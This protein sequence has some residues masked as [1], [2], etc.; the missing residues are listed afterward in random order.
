MTDPF[1]TAAV[2][3]LL[4]RGER[5]WAYYANLI[6][7][8]GSAR[9]VLVGDF[10]EPETEPDRL[11]E[12]Q[13]RSHDAEPDLSGILVEI[14]AWRDEGMR[15]LTVLDSEYPANLRTIH[16]RPPILFLRGELDAR[17]ERSVAV[18]GTRNPS[19]AGRDLAAQIATE[20]ANSGYVVVSGLALG[21]DTA[22]HLA[23]LE[24][25]QRTIAVVGTGLRRA[26]PRQ[27]TDL[28]ARIAREGAVLSQFWP[29]SPPTQQSF[30]QRNVVMSGFAL[31]TVVIEAGEK[32]GARTQARHALGHGRPVF[33]ARGVVESSTWAREYSS[34][35]G[36][37][38]F[39]GQRD[40]LALIE[41]L[42]ALDALSI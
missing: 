31:A 1:E 14:D 25:S 4:R 30:P 32:S 27:N 37:Y 41:R 7:S 6:D 12:V 36:V 39:E 15:L 38:V 33:L 21:I 34:R 29:D 9:K 8:V 26:Y 13:E 24:A 11:F 2:V 23:A 5:S 20:L 42:M 40:V 10:D 22:A 3:A 17:D 28:Q 16:N 18:V 19:D 35:P